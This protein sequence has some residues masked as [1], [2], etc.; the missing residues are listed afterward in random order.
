MGASIRHRESLYW[1][2]VHRNCGTNFSDVSFL[3]NARHLTDG[4]NFHLAKLTFMYD[5]RF[6]QLPPFMRKELEFGNDSSQGGAEVLVVAAAAKKSTKR[7]LKK[8]GP[9]PD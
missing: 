3:L 5:G 7:S 2:G 1:R 8:L 4:D 6:G 9:R